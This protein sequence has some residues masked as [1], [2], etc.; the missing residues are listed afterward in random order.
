MTIGQ[1]QNLKIFVQI[2]KNVPTFGLEIVLLGIQSLGM[3][4]LI[5]IDICRRLFIVAL[6]VITKKPETN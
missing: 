2:K 6:S 4:I 1:K 5:C 3:P